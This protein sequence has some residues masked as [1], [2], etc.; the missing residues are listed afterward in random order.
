MRKLLSKRTDRS[1]PEKKKSEI[2]VE[3]ESAQR[4]KARKIWAQDCVENKP[5]KTKNEFFVYF[6]LNLQVPK[7][8][9]IK[10]KFG[11]EQ[12]ISLVKQ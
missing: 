2:F 11:C 1:V 12:N 7:V 8:P 3:Y 10:L 9:K 6:C 5:S 4:S